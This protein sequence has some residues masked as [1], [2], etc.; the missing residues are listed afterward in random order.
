MCS[1]CGGQ[2]TY[3]SEITTFL[4]FH[5]KKKCW[6]GVDIL[7]AVHV[8]DGNVVL[9]FDFDVELVDVVHVL[10]V[11]VFIVVFLA[12]YVVVGMV[13]DDD[14]KERFRCGWG[15]CPDGFVSRSKNI[16]HGTNEHIYFIHFNNYICA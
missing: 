12:V 7:Y 13:F 8:T 14:G 15:S 11:I 2:K 3:I 9:V 10:V 4:A 6:S 1:R 5:K 16:I